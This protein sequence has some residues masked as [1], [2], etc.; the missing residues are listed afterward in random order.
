MSAS[1]TSLH[2]PIELASLTLLALCIPF[3]G[4]WAQRSLFDEYTVQPEVWHFAV[5]TVP[6]VDGQGNLNLSIPVMTVPGRG[7]DFDITFSY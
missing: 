5:P 3:R 2:C 7:I 6:G 4:A 1:R